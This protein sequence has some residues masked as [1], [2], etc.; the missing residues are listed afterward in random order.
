MIMAKNEKTVEKTLTCINCPLGCQITAV[1]KGKE[2]VSV[3]GNNCK[4]GENYARTE[5]TDPRRTVTS[6]VRVYNGTTDA[7]S[8]K[9]ERDIPKEKIF[10][11]ISELSKITVNA[12]V[13][14]G[15]IIVK[16]VCGTG[17][18]VIATKNV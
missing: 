17:V 8:V 7:V 18:N 6:T 14:I 10:D 1:L 11:V 3:T 9:T 12:P 13:K 15:D 16:D 5:L 4:R 2:V